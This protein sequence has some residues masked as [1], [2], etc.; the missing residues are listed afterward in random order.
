MLTLA[1]EHLHLRPAQAGDD[2]F[3]KELYAATRDDLRQAAIDPAMLALLVD[4]QWRAQCAGYRQAHPAADSLVV[5][6]AGAPLG[7]LLVDRSAP[8]WRIVDIALLPRARGQGHGVALLRA[9]QARAGEAGAALVLTVRR[10]NPRARR[11][12]VALGFEADG[13]DALAEQMVWRQ[14]CP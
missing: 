1:L 14:R 9:L 8:Q 6:S 3:L 4:M 11:L 2:A 12:Y 7:R 13:G 5:E 10:D